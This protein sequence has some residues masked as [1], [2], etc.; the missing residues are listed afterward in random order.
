ML[1]PADPLRHAARDYRVDRLPRPCIAAVDIERGERRPTGEC[2]G[3]CGGRDL[4]ISQ[5]DRAC[6]GARRGAYGLGGGCLPPGGGTRLGNEPEEG[7]NPGSQDPNDR[8]GPP[9]PRGATH[10]VVPRWRHLQLTGI[11]YGPESS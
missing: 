5:R 2:E 6:R 4:A 1:L 8:E 11:E 9:A 10:A 7:G 3:R